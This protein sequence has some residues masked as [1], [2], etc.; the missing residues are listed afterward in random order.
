[1][2]TPTRY[3]KPE[4][5]LFSI[6]SRTSASM[7]SIKKLFDIHGGQFLSTVDSVVRANGSSLKSVQAAV[8]PYGGTKR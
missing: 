2:S 8:S 4:D 6:S 5:S 1:M 7:T 3:L